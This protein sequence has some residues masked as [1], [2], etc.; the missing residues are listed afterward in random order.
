M[1]WIQQKLEDNSWERGVG[2]NATWQASLISSQTLGG[3]DHLGCVLDK[4]HSRKKSQMVKATVIDEDRRHTALGVCDLE[5][6]PLT[7][8]RTCH[9]QNFGLT[10]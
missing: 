4:G 8:S 6:I 9:Y 2:D 7:H 3:A 1:P 5:Y 10:T